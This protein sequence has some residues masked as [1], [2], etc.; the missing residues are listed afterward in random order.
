[1]SKITAQ[2]FY[3]D[4]DLQMMTNMTVFW[5]QIEDFVCLMFMV[6]SIMVLYVYV[7]NCLGTKKD[8]CLMIVRLI[9]RET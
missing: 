4:K 6:S 1:M 5:I 9:L 7:K 3:E 8:I 2:L